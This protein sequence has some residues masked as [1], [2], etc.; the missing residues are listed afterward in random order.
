MRTPLSSSL[1]VSAELI[2]FSSV[3]LGARASLHQQG[4]WSDCTLPALLLL[5]SIPTF[6]ATTAGMAL[7][8]TK[9][10]VLLVQL[11]PA[12]AEQGLRLLHKAL[13][14]G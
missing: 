7:R 1:G 5:P 9:A 13:S 2:I 10:R 12:E 4:G 14:T 3:S 6:L 8:A 11:R